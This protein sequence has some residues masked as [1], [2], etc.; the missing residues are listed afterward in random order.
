MLEPLLHWEPWPR[1]NHE[2]FRQYPTSAFS[3]IQFQCHGTSQA[4]FTAT[5]DSC[6]VTST[7]TIA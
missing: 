5:S 7:G 3:S 6:A 2:K 4:A 1:N